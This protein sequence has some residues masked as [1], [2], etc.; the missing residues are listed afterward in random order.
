M[1]IAGILTQAQATDNNL[2]AS[3]KQ[4]LYNNVVT[5]Y[6]SAATGLSLNAGMQLQSDGTWK[7]DGLGLTIMY[8]GPTDG[9]FYEHVPVVAYLLDNKQQSKDPEPTGIG[10]GANWEYRTIGFCFLP[11]VFM[12]SDGAGFQSDRKSQFLL[13]SLANNAILRAK[14]LPIV[15]STA[16]VGN[17]APQIGYAEIVKA[18]VHVMPRDVIQLLSVHKL[19][20]DMDIE[21]RWAVQGTN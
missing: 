19:R 10:D 16:I 2:A 8:A 6:N 4:W 3:V 21:I 14:I 20:F 5:P 15:D 17:V 1:A 13:K 11:S 18:D 7:D 9:D 12:S